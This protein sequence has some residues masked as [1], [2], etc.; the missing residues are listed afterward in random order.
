M[1]IG[2]ATLGD[3]ERQGSG[4]TIDGDLQV[5]QQVELALA[6]AGRLWPFGL[7]V[8]IVGL[9]KQDI[10]KSK[11]RDRARKHNREPGLGNIR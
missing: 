7:L 2:A 9:I 8:H 5:S 11:H 3:V 10:T 6:R 4:E 1:Q